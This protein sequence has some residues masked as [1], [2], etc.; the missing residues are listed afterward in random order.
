MNDPRARQSRFNS[1]SRG[2]WDGFASHRQIVNGVLAAGSGETRGRLCVL[3][4][5]NC[6]DLDLPAL[7][8]LFRE[9]HLVDLDLE[10]LAL[11]AERQGVADR[12]T[13]HRHGGLD[14]TGM[15]DVMAG[16]S[17]FC[18]LSDADLE[19]LV[20]WPARRVALALPA[21]FDRVASTCLLSQI[22]GN[23]FHSIGERH[24]R[25]P[26]VVRAIRLG[27]LRLLNRLA[28]PGGEVILITDVVSSD[29]VPELATVRDS[30]LPGLLARLT[31]GG[32]GLIHGV[33]PTEV[34]ETFRKDP[35]L[36]RNVAGMTELRPWL[37]RLH[38][39]VYLVYTLKYRVSA[40]RHSDPGGLT[41]PIFG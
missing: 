21:P 29:A 37:W 40:Q 6:N 1:E 32:G 16:W 30:E 9:V 11:G 31:R 41:F 26:D 28:T 17:P 25:F 3:G 2:Q 22:I 5:G 38:E 19:A 35:I 18:H 10:A 14:L 33:N 8:E 12:P 39:R 27:H 36:S 34:R 7:L 15:I 4:G 23:A 24:P 13:L 20:E